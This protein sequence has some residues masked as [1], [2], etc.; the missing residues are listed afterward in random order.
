MIHNGIE[1][2]VMQAYA[3]GFDILEHKNSKDLP[4]ASNSILTSRISRNYGGA[5]A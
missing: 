2:G 4:E 3:E 1:Y 5:V